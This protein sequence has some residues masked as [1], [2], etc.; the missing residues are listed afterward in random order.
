MAEREDCCG[1]RRERS[2][3]LRI[4]CTL[5]REKTPEGD[6]CVTIPGHLLHKPDPCIYDQFLLMQLNQPVTWDNPDVRIF[7]GGV[8][9]YTYNLTADTRYDLEIT[10]HNSSRDK[11]ALGTTVYIRWVEF[12]AGGQTRHVIDTLTAD[13]PLWPGV[14][15]VPTQWRTP[16]TPG[17]YCIEVELQHPDDGNPSNNVGW[18]NTQV[19]A[20]HSEVRRPVRVFNFYP[21]GCPPVKEG[22]G[23]VLRP[24]RVFLGWGILGALAGLVLYRIPCCTERA[25]PR[26]L[27][28]TLAGYLLLCVLGLIFESAFAAIRRSRL[29]RDPRPPQHE[30]PRN[31]NLVEIDVD[32]YVFND[33]VGKQ[34][35][36]ET[37]FAG[38]A[39]AWPARVEPPQFLFQPG[40]A[41]R[42]VEL[43][44]DA[45]DGP[46]PPANF[47]VN[48]R[49]GGAPIGGVTMSITRE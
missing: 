45:P 6:P 1:K 36:P 20:A 41:F 31:C 18:N 32:G 34:F 25:A 48:V 23:P 2:L 10:V 17:H 12:G 9:Q 44:V 27:L 4:W 13:V 8:E 38:Q 43:I 3:L 24:H 35:D 11:P 33:G 37:A 49:Q 7:L 40:E 39:P 47:N 14:S 42:D 5:T 29:R 26:M 46:G 28:F 19:H 30:R 16:A 21:K 22:G 15:V